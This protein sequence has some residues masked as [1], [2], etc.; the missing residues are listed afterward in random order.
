[1]HFERR[2]EWARSNVTVKIRAEQYM[3]TSMASL[4]RDKIQTF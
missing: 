4:H 3:Y 2:I 1:M